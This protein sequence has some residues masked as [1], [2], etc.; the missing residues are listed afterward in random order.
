M[1]CDE[2]KPSCQ[3]CIKWQG[4]CDG[5]AA[6]S[7]GTQGSSAASRA[8]VRINS[9]TLIEPNFNSS[10]FSNQSEKFYFERWLALAPNLAGGFF[11]S[12]LW[13][14]TIPQLCVGE[15]AVRYAAL[16]IGAMAKAVS[17]DMVHRSP[18]TLMKR[19]PHYRIALTYYGRALRNVGL[20]QNQDQAS[21]L[22]TA[23]LSCLLFI[24]FEMLHGNRESAIDHISY[25]LQ[26]IE[27]FIRAY[28]PPD[29]AVSFDG[30]MTKSPSPR[31]RD[32]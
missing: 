28:S 14:I 1:K 30:V 3:R 23:L 31:L 2:A 11:D 20:Q 19:G 21:G 9:P 7:A 24:C 13:T 32:D 29:S 15:S 25:G 10:V 18:A 17:P 6:S 12:P 4:F 5:Y 27:Q 8:L 16:A 26:I 22:R